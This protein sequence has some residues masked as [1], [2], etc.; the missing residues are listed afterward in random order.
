MLSL[1]QLKSLCPNLLCHKKAILKKCLLFQGLVIDQLLQDSNSETGRRRIIYL[2][3]GGG[4]FCPTLRLA[5]GDHVMPRKDYPL[6]KRI[7]KNRAH[8]KASVHEWSNGDELCKILL[9]LINTT[10][11]EDISLDNSS[12]E[13]HPKANGIN[14]GHCESQ[15]L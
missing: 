4:D 7:C 6:W 10:S 13:A 2:G 12:S 5:T 15:D 8:I 14:L 3:D 11:A 9:H 1:V